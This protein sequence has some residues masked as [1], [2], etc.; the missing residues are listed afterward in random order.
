MKLRQ[1]WESGRTT[2]QGMLAERGKDERS[3]GSVWMT[4]WQKSRGEEG[5]V[6]VMSVNE[7]QE[8]DSD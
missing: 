6:W 2:C 7:G 5:R 3:G 4:V 1:S 8:G